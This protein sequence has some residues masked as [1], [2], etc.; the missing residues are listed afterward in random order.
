MKMEEYH[1]GRKGRKYGIWNSVRKCFQFGICEDTP[2]KAVHRL[3]EKIG[4]DAYK[5]RFEP[6]A[7]PKNAV[8]GGASPCELCRY[9]PP[10]SLPGKPCGLCPAASR[11]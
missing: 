4:K 7:L 8:A 11:N 6:R 5:W 9:Y 3:H 2:A 1:H 10:S